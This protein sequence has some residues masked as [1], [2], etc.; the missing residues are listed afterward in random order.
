MYDLI[1]CRDQG[2]VLAALVQRHERLFL[3]LVRGLFVGTAEAGPAEED[4]DR[5]KKKKGQKKSAESRELC[6]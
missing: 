5:A 2:R 6:P 1:V 4:E 3:L